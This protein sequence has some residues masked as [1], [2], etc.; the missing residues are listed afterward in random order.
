MSFFSWCRNHRKLVWLW[1][2][3]VGFVLIY[4]LW[5][6]FTAA[7]LKVPFNN[8]RLFLLAFVGTIGTVMALVILTALVGILFAYTRKSDD[9]LTDLTI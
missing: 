8:G 9:S 4:V 7:I 3:L 2:G 1:A 6:V 5:I